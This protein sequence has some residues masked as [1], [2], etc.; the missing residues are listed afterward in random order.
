MFFML[1]TCEEIDGFLLTQAVMSREM[2]E[3]SGL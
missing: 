2:R 1:Q 3:Y